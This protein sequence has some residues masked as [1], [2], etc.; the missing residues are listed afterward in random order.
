M[1]R[2]VQISS[3]E[4]WAGEP[5]SWHRPPRMIGGHAAGAVVIASSDAYVVAVRQVLAYPVGVEFDVEAHARRLKLHGAQS[6]SDPVDPF[7]PIDPDGPARPR[8]CVRFGDGPEAAQDD[9]AGLRSGRGPMMVMSGCESS[10]GGPDDPVD[11]RLTLWI[12]PLP[13]SAPITVTCTWPA[14]G[15]RGAAIV[16]DGD[17]IHT[18]AESAQPFWQ[19]SGS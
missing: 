7:D 11:M 3:G 2:N 15:L 19:P 8:F 17:V 1:L 18:A 6:D 12:T 9:E 13:P 16:L 4:S 10:Y 14:Q 5:V